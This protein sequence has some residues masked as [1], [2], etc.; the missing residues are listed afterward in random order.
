MERLDV[1]ETPQAQSKVEISLE[2]MKYIHI[3]TCVHTCT[4]THT[5]N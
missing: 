2:N 3:S 5:Q 4:Y 1:K